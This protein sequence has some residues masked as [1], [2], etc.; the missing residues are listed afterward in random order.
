MSHFTVTVIGEDWEDQLEPFNEELR[1]KF[2]IEVEAGDFEKEATQNIFS[3]WY[4]NSFGLFAMDHI[5][6]K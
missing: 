4:F 2:E 1:T 6:Y 3:G 5:S